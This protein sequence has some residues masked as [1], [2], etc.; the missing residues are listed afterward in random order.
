MAVFP[1]NEKI[2]LRNSSEW[3]SY[4]A[5]ETLIQAYGTVT[6]KPVRY[7]NRGFIWFLADH[8]ITNVHEV[9]D[10]EGDIGFTWY[11]E[12]D[13][14]G[15]QCSFMETDSS[16]KGIEFQ[17]TIEGKKH[18]V[19]ANTL[20]KEPSDV[21]TDIFNLNPNVQFQ[22]SDIDIYKRDCQEL[23][24]QIDGI[25]GDHDQSTQY[26]FNQIKASTGSVWGGALKNIFRIFPRIEVPEAEY[27]AKNLTKKNLYTVN[28]VSNYNDIKTILRINYNF[29]HVTGVP[30]EVL[31]LESVEGVKKYRL[32][33]EVN[34]YWIRS[35]RLAWKIGERILKFWARK[36]WKVTFSSQEELISGEYSNFNH[37]GIP[38]DQA[39]YMVLKSNVKPT[40]T[41]GDY[42][43]YI[44]VGTIPEVAIT[45]QS[46][47]FD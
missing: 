38:G 47:S 36:K 37:P 33:K 18:P 19:T 26:Y 5:V 7:D 31:Q 13:H 34:F 15:N 17:A 27:I 12:I 1:L 39:D 4:E 23:G 43:I 41:G 29:N 10:E 32:T 42:S 20:I 21:I 40:G 6:I 28:A 45:Y 35:G 3:P 24:I 22:E 25:L 16:M 2:N 44:P 11:N 8:P 14:L 30:Q 9:R 46:E